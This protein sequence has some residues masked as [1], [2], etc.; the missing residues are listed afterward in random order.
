MCVVRA[1]GE[2]GRGDGKGCAD[3]VW[4]SFMMD[5][6]LL[7]EAVFWENKGRILEADIAGRCGLE[8]RGVG[9]E[10]FLLNGNEIFVIELATSIFCFMR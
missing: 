7:R 6:G 9:T 1:S 5:E 4:M 10:N 2:G 3:V 8:G